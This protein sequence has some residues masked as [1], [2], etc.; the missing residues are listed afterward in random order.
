MIY[1]EFS[2][3]NDCLQ[4]FNAVGLQ[5]DAV[6]KIL[7]RPGNENKLSLKI[8]SQHISEKIQKV[9]ELQ[10]SG[11]IG[12]SAWLFETVGQDTIP[13]YKSHPI[14]EIL[15]VKTEKDFGSES[16]KVCEIFFAIQSLEIRKQNPKTG[17]DKVI[18]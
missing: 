5:E 11:K 9:A 16:D 12:F 17:V 15:V 8:D 3:E 7:F 18:L 2:S 14:L 10:Y 1:N 13:I 4:F 6:Q